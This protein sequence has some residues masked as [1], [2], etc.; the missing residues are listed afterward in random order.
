MAEGEEYEVEAIL[1][2]Q[3]RC[4]KTQYLVK[5]TGYP[6]WELSWEDESNLSNAQEKLEDYKAR[7]RPDVPVTRKGRSRK[8]HKG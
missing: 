8:R 7:R 3:K 6:D 5:W 1:D 2:E 4:G